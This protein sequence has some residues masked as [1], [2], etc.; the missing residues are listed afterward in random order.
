MKRP[1]A[2]LFLLLTLLPLTTEAGNTTVCCQEK[3]Y[4][5]IIGE[6]W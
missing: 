3:T 4:G 2:V 5:G 1:L 6:V